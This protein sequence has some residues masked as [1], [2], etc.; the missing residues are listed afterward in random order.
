[1]RHYI[2]R[3]TALVTS[4]LL[5]VGL[6]TA[7]PRAWG[8]QGH[9]VLALVASANLTTAARANVRRLLPDET[10]ADVAN[11][12]D[13]YISGN[14]QTAPWHYVNIPSDADAYNRDRDCP[15]QPGVAAGSFNDRWR[16][17]IIDRI[18]YHQERLAN[19]SLDRADRA[20]A[21]KF[22]VHFVGDLHQPFHAIDVA[23]GGNDIPVVAFGS[24]DCR[25]SDGTTFPCNLHGMWD[26]QMIARR[27]LSDAQYVAALSARI[28]RHRKDASTSA[29]S[30]TAWALESLA[31]AR[32]AL[33]PKQG[34]VDDAYYRAQIAAIDDRLAIGGLRLAAMINKSLP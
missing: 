28:A 30:P 23:R 4:L 24:P 18:L 19:R 16:D 9:R 17:C 21:L 12:A 11:W 26:T 2:G 34:V 33:L 14:T 22:L 13:Q 7:T 6:S 8:V 25:R 31:L 10:L 5:L 3:T 32:T 27:S 15:R 29:G 1:M 20:I